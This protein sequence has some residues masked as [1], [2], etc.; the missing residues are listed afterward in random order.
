MP[1]VRTYDDPEVMFKITPDGKSAIHTTVIG[2]EAFDKALND[3]WQPMELL[4]RS[5][6]FPTT[7]YRPDGQTLIVQNQAEKDAEMAKGWETKRYPA[8]LLRENYDEAAWPAEPGSAA[9]MKAAQ[10][11]NAQT[12]ELALQLVSANTRAADQDKAIA[13]LKAQM[14]ELLQAKAKK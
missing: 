6:P 13:E 8:P 9:A 10:T 3:G 11:N 5:L 4:P 14:A 2:K 12:V 1:L 7:L